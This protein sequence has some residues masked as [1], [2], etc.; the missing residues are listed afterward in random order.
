MTVLAQRILAIA[1]TGGLMLVNLELV[2]RKRLMERYALLWLFS[3]AV[4][5]VLAAWKGLLT[6]ISSAV[7]VH[8]PPALLFAVAFGFELLL[9]LHFSLTISRL[10]DQNK[11]LAQ[12]LGLVQQ[13]VEEQEARL[14]R[15]EQLL[16]DARGPEGSRRGDSPEPELSRVH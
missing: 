15:Q 8:Y 16:G 7:G 6:A 9:L 4:L 10:T 13:Q 1:L 2:R 5:I 14:A 3:T 11:V 12:R